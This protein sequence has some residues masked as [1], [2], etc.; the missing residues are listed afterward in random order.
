MIG[1]RSKRFVS[2]VLWFS[3]IN[4]TLLFLFILNKC[5]CIYKWHINPW[6]ITDLINCL[7]VSGR[8]WLYLKWKSHFWRRFWMNK[9]ICSVN[10]N[11]LT[12]CDLLLF[13]LKSNSAAVKSDVEIAPQPLNFPSFHFSVLFVS[14]ISSLF[15]CCFL[16]ES[17]F[18]K[19]LPFLCNTNMFVP[20][21]LS[22]LTWAPPLG[23]VERG[24]TFGGRTMAAV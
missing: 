19:H 16:P 15:F 10:E 7:K 20:E 17:L 2:P 6:N 9:C 12:T 23:E 22:T 14:L 3:Y 4:D 21:K 11:Y 18:F 24:S 8:K 5:I 1:A 13:S